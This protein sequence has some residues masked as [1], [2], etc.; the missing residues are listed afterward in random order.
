MLLVPLRLT[1]NQ[2]TC[3]KY[4]IDISAP[5]LGNITKQTAAVS[6]D[7][8]ARMESKYRLDSHVKAYWRLRK[9]RDKRCKPRENYLGGK[10]EGTFR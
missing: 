4:G 1:V 9:R 6:F 3:V 7:L 8:C 10:G 5:G 2:S